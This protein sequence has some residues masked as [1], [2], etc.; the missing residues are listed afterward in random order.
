VVGLV[1]RCNESVFDARHPVSAVGA[2]RRRDDTLSRRRALPRRALCWCADTWRCAL[3]CRADVLSSFLVSLVP[4]SP[5]L[6]AGLAE[7]I[8][9]ATPGD[10][11]WVVAASV[12]RCDGGGVR[13]RLVPPS[14]SS[15]RAIGLKLRRSSECT[16]ELAPMGR[17]RRTA[18]AG[19]VPAAAASSWTCGTPSS[20]IWRTTALRRPTMVMSG[21]SA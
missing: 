7:V 12:V 2:L 4:S 14:V 11:R 16:L 10:K 15:P 8:A 1:P 19:R 3:G 20:A 6:K 17:R 21:A 9:A 18:D 5:R 13:V